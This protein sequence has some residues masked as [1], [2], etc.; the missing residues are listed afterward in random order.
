MSE[1]NIF[2]FEIDSILAQLVS[3]D[4]SANEI[5][6]LSLDFKNLPLVE[7]INIKKNP[8]RS[9]RVTNLLTF[10]L[11]TLVSQLPIHLEHLEITKSYV[12]NLDWIK[13]FYQ[14]DSLTM[15]DLSLGSKYSSILMDSV[16]QV[17]AEYIRINDLDLGDVTFSDTWNNSHCELIDLSGNMINNINFDLQLF[18]HLKSMDLGSN[19]LRRLKIEYEKF[20]VLE[21]L[22]LTNNNLKSIDIR[23]IGRIKTLKQIRLSG[24][25]IKRKHQRRILDQI[26]KHGLEIEVIF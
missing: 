20:P 4:L 2:S 18:G 16:A 23:E 5:S 22:D 25:R 1:N 11:E 8:L 21:Q 6:K 26:G 17:N 14:I 12:Q 19:R 7:T 9:V 3:I 10:N 24:N 13:R 15:A